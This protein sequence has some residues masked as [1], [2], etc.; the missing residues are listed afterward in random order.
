MGQDARDRRCLLWLRRGIKPSRSRC[1]AFRDRAATLLGDWHRQVLRAAVAEGLTTAGSGSLDGTLIAAGASRH[2]LLNL[3]RLGQRLEE[4]D[5]VIAADK[6]GQDPGVIP[7]WMAHP[8]R[9][10]TAAA[11]PL[12]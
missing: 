9:D 10:S 5:S 3:A 4:F 8:S 7:G 6:A 2:R 11:P 1:Y 12:P